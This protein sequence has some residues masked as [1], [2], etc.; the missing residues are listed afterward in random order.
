MRLQ[1]VKPNVKDKKGTH[2]ASTWTTNDRASS[3]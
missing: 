2:Y 3:D 1:Q